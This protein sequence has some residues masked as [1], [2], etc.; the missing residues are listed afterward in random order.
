MDALIVINEMNEPES[1][2]DRHFVD[3]NADGQRSPLDA[4]MVINRMNRGGGSDHGSRPGP[5]V[6]PTALGDARA[7]DGTGNN[8]GDP[9]LGSSGE[10]LLR[11]SPADYGD[12]VST[13]AVEA[14]TPRSS[15]P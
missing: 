1:R 10:Q 2:S 9:E 5:I 7:I 11:V 12:G 14:R 8:L 6:I 3:V 13:P 15:G 4:L